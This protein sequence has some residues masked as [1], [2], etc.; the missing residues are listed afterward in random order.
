MSHPIR[1]AI[2]DMYNGEPNQGMRCIIDIINRFNQI[3]TF[4]IFDVRGKSEFPDIQKYDIF[5]STGGPG[6]PLEGDGWDL[7]WYDFID[8]LWHWNKDQK[9]KKHMLFICHSFQ[10]ACHHFGLATINKRKAT[11]FGVMTIHKTEAGSNDPILEG[12]NN[13]FY[14]ID[15]RDYQVVQPKLSI[16]SKKGAMIIAL[17]KI[18]THVEYERAIMGVRFSDEFVGLQF[19]PEADALSFVANL[20]NKE[21]R[22]HIIAMKGKTKFRDMLEDLLDEDKIYKTNETIIP[23]FLRIAINDL[24]KHRKSLSN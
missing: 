13:P 8:T 19:H 14:A 15:S 17:E 9:V 24:M 23:N 22:E 21:R 5:I 18:R 16:F 12:L 20:K 4:Q 1:I 11:S 7:K 3:A 2:L 6:N 10:M